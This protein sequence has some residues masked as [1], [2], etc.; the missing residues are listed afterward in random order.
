MLGGTAGL[1]LALYLLGRAYPG[2]GADVLDWQPTRSAETEAQNE[3][4][5]L[6]ALMEIANR[7]RR[8]RGEPELTEE[9]LNELVSSEQQETAKR[10][11]DYIAEVELTQMLEAKNA[12]RRSKGLPE[13]GLEEYRA[14]IMEEEGL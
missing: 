7:R 5:E 4:D 6:E 10:R 14:K 9:S 1:V 13:I 3:I 8:R 2:S 12:R 11:D